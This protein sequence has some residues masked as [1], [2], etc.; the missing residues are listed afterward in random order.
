MNW[1]LLLLAV[2]SYEVIWWAVR[3]VGRYENSCCVTVPF[4]FKGCS[5]GCFVFIFLSTNPMKKVAGSVDSNMW[6]VTDV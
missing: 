5:W 1:I 3:F 6:K 2:Q 4:I